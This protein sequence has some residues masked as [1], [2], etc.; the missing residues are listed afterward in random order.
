GWICV[1]PPYAKQ[2]LT[3]TGLS[4]TCG[5]EF[6]FDFASYIDSG[7][8]PQLV[9]GEIVYAQAWVSDPSGV[10]HGTLTDAIAFRVTE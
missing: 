8:D 5:G 3:Q 2:L 10:G 1:R 6:D 9:P 4:T 7:V